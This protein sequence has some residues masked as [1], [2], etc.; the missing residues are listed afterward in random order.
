MYEPHFN[1]S[2]P[3]RGYNYAPHVFG[4]EFVGAP[5]PT[6]VV[7]PE[8]NFPVAAVV[9][10]V[11]AGALAAYFIYEATK[12]PVQKKINRAAMKILGEEAK[13]QGTAAVRHAGRAAGDVFARA[14]DRHVATPRHK[15]KIKVVHYEAVPVTK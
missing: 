15:P 14:I 10:I 8:K 5:P 3:H 2:Y 9:G 6:V 11:V 4:A 13:R 7:V 12:G 1:P